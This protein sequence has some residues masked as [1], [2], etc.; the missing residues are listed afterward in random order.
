MKDLHAWWEN[1]RVRSEDWSIPAV[2]ARPSLPGLGESEIIDL[3]NRVVDSHQLSE[4][5]NG[6]RTSGMRFPAEPPRSLRDYPEY[7]SNLLDLNSASACTYTRDYCLSV[8]PRATSAVLEFIQPFTE[9]FGVP[10]KGINVVL[11]GGSYAE[12]WIGLHNDF[13]RTVLMP[14]SGRKEM[15][16]W[17]PDYF[18]GRLTETGPSANGRCFGPVDVGVYSKDAVVCRATA[19]EVIFIPERWWHYNQLPESEPT[20]T[21]SIGMFSGLDANGRGE[22]R[23]VEALASGVYPVKNV[24]GVSFREQ[25]ALAVEALLVQSTGGL[26]GD[27]SSIPADDPALPTYTVPVGPGRAVRIERGEASL[28][29]WDESHLPSAEVGAGH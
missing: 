22:F 14:F 21:L 19:G 27:F 12:T 16:L 23:L 20:L 28:V 26:F 15:L 25:V 5:I 6:R 24:G 1:L 18:D 2:V 11:I 8:S 29:D 17:E 9:R 7:A 10:D 3:H 13:C 4:N